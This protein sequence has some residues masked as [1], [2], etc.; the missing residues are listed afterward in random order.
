MDNLMVDKR[1]Y[2]SGKVLMMHL[3]P[4]DFLWCALGT[5]TGLYAWA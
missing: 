4:L 1:E 2:V 5:S 3:I